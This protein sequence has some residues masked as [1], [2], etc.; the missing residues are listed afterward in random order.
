MLGGAL[1]LD[2]R[3]ALGA[4]DVHVHL[5]LRVLD[6]GQIEHD[7]AVDD[8]DRDGGDGRAQRAGV[9]ERAG[10]HELADGERERDPR[11]GD[12][13]HA[14]AA[15]GGEHVAVHVDGPLAEVL[16]ID[17]GAERAADQALDLLAAPAGVA[18]AARVRRARQHGVLGGQPALALADE[19]P[20]HAGLDA[21]GAQDPGVAELDQRRALRVLLIVRD[22]LERAELIGA[23][24]IE[25]HGAHTTPNVARGAS[26]T[27][28]A[29]MTDD[30]RR[31][32]GRGPVLAEPA[33]GDTLPFG[34]PLAAQGRAGAGGDG[35]GASGGRRVGWDW[36][37]RWRHQ[38]LAGGLGL[39]ETIA[40]PAEL[41]AG[42]VPPAKA[43]KASGT[44]RRAGP[45]S[46]CCRRRG[47]IGGARGVA[48]RL[49][50]RRRRAIRPKAGAED[51]AEALSLEP[52]Q[53]IG[54]FVIRKHLGEGGMGVVLAGHD[55]ELGRR[56]AIKLVRTD[57]DR[58]PY[59]ARLM[60]EA[61][62]M[63]RLE[64]PN[65]V[66]LYEIG[67]E[68]GR[69][70]VAMELVDGVTLTDWLAG[71]RRP[72]REVLAMFAQIGAGLAAVHRAGLVH[73]DFKP[74]N[75]LIDRAGRPRVADLGLARLDPEAAASAAESPAF[76]GTLTR[77]GVMMGTPGY[78]APEQQAGSA[79]DAR[80]SVQLLRRA[81][82]GALGGRIVRIDRRTWRHVPGAVRGI[83]ERGL[84]FEP[85]ERFASMDELV[86]ALGQRRAPARRGDQRRDRG[87][88]DRGR[89]RHDG[90]RDVARP[91][92]A[93]P[94]SLRRLQP[95]HPRRPRR[96]PR[97]RR[98]SKRRSRR[99]R[100]RGDTSA[101]PAL[102]GA[103]ARI[104][105]AFATPG[106]RRRGR[107]AARREQAAGGRADRAEREQREDVPEEQVLRVR[108]GAP[109]IDEG[110]G[111]RAARDAQG[112]PGQPRVRGRRAAPEVQHR[113]DRRDAR[114]SSRASSSGT[115]A[116]RATGASSPRRARRAR[117]STPGGGA[118]SPPR[119]RRAR[120]R[121]GL[122]IEGRAGTPAPWRPPRWRAA[123]A[124]VEPQ[125]RRPP[126]RAEAAGERED[127]ERRAS[128][129]AAQHEPADAATLARGAPARPPRSR[130]CAPSSRPSRHRRH[131]PAS[132]APPASPASPA[133]PA[134]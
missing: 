97:P 69:L 96:R 23:P 124:A 132:P 78:M 102:A 15:V 77:S 127:R 55:P 113:G 81:P 33:P 70:F 16:E 61:Q 89:D 50:G 80:G 22:D 38:R 45:R 99:A 95:R 37:R 32:A 88:G 58:P 117:A 19:E 109:E 53:R 20:G 82:R 1:H 51:A 34:A 108:D 40:A 93:R 123:P 11:A 118:A 12:R 60:R 41:P 65:V 17:G 48:A 120:P 21:R 29:A 125:R 4:D 75:V 49:G 28:G 115:P 39:A 94:A 134:A 110:P 122:S 92:R 56:V 64:H 76:A 106:R 114:R 112:E 13:G 87:R 2:Q 90:V 86:S 71:E 73:R 63:A 3:A 111:E 59:R 85:G 26:A 129:G 6:V 131:A 68:Q 31:A 107:Q 57:V 24:A 101:A 9:G 47:G 52:G 5:G 74:D 36:R 10:P 84:A 98:R 104:G 133:S 62:A 8:A 18:L 43:V 128:A 103:Q 83:V 14:G 44:D 119:S 27:I 116:A 105:R 54:R 126:R 72:W 46:I 100:R 130:G 121:T 91:G 42:T 25:S 7:L 67:S 30:G 66:R 35:G 79:V